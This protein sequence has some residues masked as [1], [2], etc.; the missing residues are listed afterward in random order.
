M[1][2]AGGRQEV[3]GNGQ[4]LGANKDGTTHGPEKMVQRAKTVT[5]MYKSKQREKGTKKR[6]DTT[7]QKNSDNGVQEQTERKRQKEQ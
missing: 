7:E 4:E 2:G 3:E 6:S 5:M 1:G